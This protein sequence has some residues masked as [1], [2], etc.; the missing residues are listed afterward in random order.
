MVN[1]RA[2]RWGERARV[3][4]LGVLLIVLAGIHLLLPVWS[5]EPMALSLILAM[6]AAGSGGYLLIRP[7]D[8]VRRAATISER[9]GAKSERGRRRLDESSE[10]DRGP[11]R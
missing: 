10:R 6:V 7:S 4:M 9:R 5:R 3:R 2:K 11:N 8:L 1:P